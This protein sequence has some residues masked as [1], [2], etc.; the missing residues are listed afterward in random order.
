MSLLRFLRGHVEE[1]TRGVWSGP[2]TSSSPE[3]ARL[4][5]APPVSAGVSVTEDSA[6]RVSAFFAAVSTISWDV[7]S[8]PLKLYKR[9]PTGGKTEFDTHPLYRMLHASPNLEQTSFQLRAALMINVLCTGNAF[10]EIGRD[11]LNRPRA[12]W[13]VEPG[14]VAIIREHGRLRY[15]VIQTDGGTVTLEAADMVHLVGPSPNGVVGLNTIDVARE[16]LGLAIASERFGG[17]YFANGAQLG[18]VLATNVTGQKPKKPR[19]GDRRPTSGRQ[20]IS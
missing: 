16:A 3:L 17:K 2:L 7:A 14:R 9:L 11:P 19:G 6:L 8:L 12:L 10:A 18:G 4:W 15:R 1:E 13:H 5:A 20:P